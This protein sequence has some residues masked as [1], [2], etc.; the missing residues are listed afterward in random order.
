MSAKG[1][2]VQ[3]RPK[4]A[5]SGY[6]EVAR[7]QSRSCPDFG[8]RA[9]FGPMSADACPDR[10]QFGPKSDQSKP[11]LGVLWPE[12]GSTAE[13]EGK[14]QTWP[15]RGPMSTLVYQSRAKPG[16]TPARLGQRRPNLGPCRADSGQ[17]WAANC[18]GWP[19]HM[20]GT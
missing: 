2:D 14:L 20:S 1:P 6:T 4:P 17:S 7:G 13:L 16:P 5:L 18:H 3:F 9:N 11:M 15:D 19:G 12:V 8:P 10:G